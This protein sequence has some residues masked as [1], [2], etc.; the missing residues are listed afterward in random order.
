MGGQLR[1]NSIDLAVVARSRPTPSIRHIDG[2][3][4]TIGTAPVP[5]QRVYHPQAIRAEPFAHPFHFPAPCIA[6]I[7][8]FPYPCRGDTTDSTLGLGIKVHGKNLS[9]ER[10]KAGPID[11]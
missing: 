2:I 9:P 11:C 10:E 3:T 6:L 1:R 7:N 4:V 5:A 8:V